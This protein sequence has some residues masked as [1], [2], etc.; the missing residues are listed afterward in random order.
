MNE[1]VT[2]I[3]MSEQMGEWMSTLMNKWKNESA[4]EEE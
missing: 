1:C 4:N 2:R 3:P